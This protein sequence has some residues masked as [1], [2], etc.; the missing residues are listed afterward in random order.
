L[1][2][3]NFPEDVVHPPLGVVVVVEAEVVLEESD[4]F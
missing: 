3:A 2:Q 1:L 4:D